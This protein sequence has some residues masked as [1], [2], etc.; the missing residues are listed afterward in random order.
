M[1]ARTHA[2][3]LGGL[4]LS[5]LAA[6]SA[7][8]SPADEPKT[9]DDYVRELHNCSPS[10]YKADTPSWAAP[11]LAARKICGYLDYP[12]EQTS[13]GSAKSNWGSVEQ[14]GTPADDPTE[15]ATCKFPPTTQGKW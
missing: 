6:P 7:T 5:L 9:A 3:V 14:P 13:A 15:V 8:A 1:A 2:V 10:C 12:I 11:K 4:L